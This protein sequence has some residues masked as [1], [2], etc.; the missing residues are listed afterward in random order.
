MRKK[1]T[2]RGWDYWKDSNKEG[3]ECEVSIERRGRRIITASDNLGIEIEN[4]TELDDNSKAV[5]VA[6]TGDMCAFTDIR[7]K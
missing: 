5:Y 4:T 6:L 2:F 7:L 1:E 3:M